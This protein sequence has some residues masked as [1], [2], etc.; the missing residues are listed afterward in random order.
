MSGRPIIKT[1]DGREFKGF[2][3]VKL[4]VVGVLLQ[5]KA[6]VLDYLI[7]GVDIVISMSIT[8]WLGCIVAVDCVKFS[9]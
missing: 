1:I 7:D 8:N 3:T 5:V 9:V 6:I 2:S 4:L